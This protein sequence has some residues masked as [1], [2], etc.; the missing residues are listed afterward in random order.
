MAWVIPVIYFNLSFP[1]TN[2]NW[3]KIDT[4][5]IHFP[6]SFAWGTATAAHQVEGDNTN[7]NW[8]DWEHQLDENNQP[9]IHNGDKSILAADHW[10]R[11]PDDIKLMKDLGV[12]H[13]RFSIE[14]SKIEPENGNYD[15]KAIQHYRDLCDSLL[16]NNITPVVTLHHFTHPIWFEKLGA[17]EKR[18][19][20]DHFIDYSEYAF[21]NLKDLVPIWCTINEP[22][23]FVSQGYFN[24]IFPPGKK[25][26]VLAAAVLENLLYAHTKTYK[27]L[28][29][30]DGGDQA[31]IGLVKN[32]FQFDP[33]RRWHILDWA[34]SKVL[35]NVFTHSTLDYF[36]KGHATFSL[37]GIVKKHLK[38]NDAIGAMDFIGLNYYSRM[39]VKGKANI[40]EPFVFEKRKKDI[41]TDMDYALYPEGF[42]KALQTI[43]T[44]EK[45]IYVTENGV[46]DRGN[47]IREIFIKRYL[48]ALNKGIQ[49]GL[50]IRGYF[51]WTL[52]DNFEWAEGYKMKFGLYEVNFE[53]QARILRESSS[54]FAKMVKKPGIDS[55]GY[56]VNIGDIAPNF[57]MEYLTGEKVTLSDLRGKVVV[58]QFTASWCSVCRKEMPHLEKDVWKQFKEKGLVLIGVDRDEP[59]ETVIQ[60]QK[61]M[62]TTYP[63]ALD[64]GAKIFGLF[65]DKNSGVTRNVIIDQQGKIV[66]LTRLFEKDE[67]DQMIEVIKSLL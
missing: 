30:L 65:A 55:R 24:G 43:S 19:N 5:N 57:T 44:L 17:F 27:H 38:N 3:D 54:L 15:P 61:D 9:R 6:N 32:I 29:N 67:Y 63:L 52:M 34:F 36:K 64:P 48:Y 33:L 28:K 51:Y 37:P 47:N 13:Y 26:P 1:E 53:T 22:S 20:I 31:Q 10:N 16:K 58:L 49:D 56:I 7:N 42:Y 41:Q 18:E 12:N 23:V 2:W 25:D 11:Y 14:W 8:Y 66:F 21:N 46:A 45:P 40:S 35:N 60:F 4:Q 39:H 50:D 59:I 62:G